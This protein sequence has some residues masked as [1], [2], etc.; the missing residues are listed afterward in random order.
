MELNLKPG[1]ICELDEITIKVDQHKEHALLQRYKVKFTGRNFL[2]L[3]PTDEDEANGFRSGRLMQRIPVED[4]MQVKKLGL[5]VYGGKSIH[6][7]IYCLPEQR[8]AALCL[9]IADVDKFVVDFL[10]GAQKL[11]K[12]WTSRD[13][14]AQPIAR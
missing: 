11:F 5:D 6:R 10:D 3:R 1:Q 8:G 14:E 2:P 9:L 13:K 12:T 7:Y 4:L